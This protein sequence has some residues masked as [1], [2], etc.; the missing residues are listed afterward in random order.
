MQMR[1]RR[2]S[3]AQG[4]TLIEVLVSLAIVALALSA[5]LASVSQQIR[6]AAAIQERTYANWVAQNQLAELRLRNELPE[7]G[8]TDDE[9]RLG[10]IDWVLNTNISETGV[11]NL[12]RVDV[13]VS[14]A[15]SGEFVRSVTGFIGE[16]GIPG[17]ANLAWT[18]S[19][20]ASGQDR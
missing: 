8:E 7:V 19:S 13:R 16:P 15:E 5:I 2:A 9:A 17:Q 20:Q 4:F 1:F 10:E 6:A 11:E 3:A 12:F 14:Y 18:S